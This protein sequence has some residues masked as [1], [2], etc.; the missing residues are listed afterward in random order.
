MTQNPKADIVLEHNRLETHEFLRNRNAYYVIKRAIDFS[1]AFLGLIFLLPLFLFLMVLIRIDSPGPVFF[2][3][4]RVGTKCFRA[5]NRSYWQPFLFKFIKFRT[6]VNNADP[7]L[8]QNFVKSYI[9]GDDKGMNTCQSEQTEVKKLIHDPRVTR[10]GRILR[11]TSLDEL[12]Q[13]L[14]ILKGDMSLVGP[15]P[16]IPYEVKTYQPWHYQR[17]QG[18]QGLTGLWQVTARSSATFDD[19]V[20]L[21]IEYLE[22]QSTRLDLIILLKTP[23][24][25]LCCKGAH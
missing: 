4:L 15:R 22:N 9:T 23:Y 5:N 8:H 10:V 13:L 14:N 17:F 1:V 21:D 18:M 12:P 20:K 24:V 3:Q 2:I 6:M 11:K 7:S 16:A 25:V 19:M